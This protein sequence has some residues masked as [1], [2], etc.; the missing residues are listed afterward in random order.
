MA[1]TKIQWCD[2]VWN[3]VT[4]CSPISEGCKNCWA[5]R[6]ALRLREMGVYPDDMRHPFDI[7][8]WPA[9]FEQPYHWKKP[10]RVF[11][12][13]M[14]DLFHDEVAWDYI[15]D[16]FQAIWSNHIHTFQVLTKRPERMAEFMRRNP[17]SAYPNISNV[18][19]GVS[20]ENQEW[21]EKRIPQLLQIPATIR[22]VSLEPLLEP[23]NLSRI[24]FLSQEEPKFWVVVG[25]ESGPGR[26]SCNIEWVRE[27]VRQCTIAGFPVFVKQ[28][29]INGKVSHDMNQW[30]KELRIQEYPHA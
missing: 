9:R 10:S 22:W 23:I 20:C 6:Y 1:N 15:L 12:C 14:G 13:S 27:I 8:L 18:W 28:L 29:S 5:K 2:K 26:R 4:G 19:L 3:P 7:R 17:Y 11:V 25:C 21:A 30:P 24:N 16:V